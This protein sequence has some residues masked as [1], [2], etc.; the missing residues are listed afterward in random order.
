MCVGNFVPAW[1]R[2]DAQCESV[3]AQKHLFVEDPFHRGLIGCFVLVELQECY[4]I[5]SS[6]F[7]SRNVMRED[8]SWKLKEMRVWMLYVLEFGKVNR[9]LQNEERMTMLVSIKQ[10]F[11]VC[12]TDCWYFELL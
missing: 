12:N 2:L 5:V 6:I 1:A 3:R 7:C 10:L 4:V 9:W 11:I 8:Y